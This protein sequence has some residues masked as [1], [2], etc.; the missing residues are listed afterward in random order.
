MIIE[1]YGCPGCGKTYLIQ[2]I[3]GQTNTVAM[4]DSNIK[5]ML[6][7]IAK[8]TSLLS[9]KSMRLNRKILSC[10]K[11]E[12]DKPLYV[13]KVVEYF[14]RN[15]VLLSFGYRHIKKD[16]FMAEGL[17][18]RVVSMAVNFG[19]N[20]DVVDR[21]MLVLSDE[22]KD[23]HPFYLEVDV[24]TCFR[25]IK[26]RNRHETQMDELDDKDLRS[27]LKEYEKLFSYVTD[28]YNFEKVTRDDYRPI[29][30]V[31]K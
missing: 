8:K 29:E 23:V 20:S 2:R 30:E 17:V 31:I 5:N 18:H 19:W 28:N 4:S 3:T 24:E 13:N 11:N 21:I 26:E 12:N 27:F 7:N 9:P 1:L 22:M 15:I 10:V 14:V 6:I 25:S 16:M